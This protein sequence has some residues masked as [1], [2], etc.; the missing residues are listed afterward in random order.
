MNLRLQNRL[1]KLEVG[2][3]VF[4]LVY[5]ALDLMFNHLAPTLKLPFFS[6]LSTFVSMI[7][8]ATLLIAGGGLLKK[9]ERWPYVWQVPLVLWLLIA[10][11][12]TL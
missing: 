8:A 7:T 1:G 12:A 6:G 9:S 10:F 3:G 2:V 11:L 4:F 5:V